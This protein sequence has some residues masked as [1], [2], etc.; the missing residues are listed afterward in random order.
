GRRAVV[1][2]YFVPACYPEYDQALLRG[3]D[4][5]T[6]AGIPIVIGARSFDVNGKPLGC[7]EI[8]AAAH[9]IGALHGAHPESL[10]GEFVVP[11]CIRHGLSPPV[12]SLSIAGFAAARFPDSILDLRPEGQRVIVC[13]RRRHFEPGQREWRTETDAF[14]VAH[15]GRDELSGFLYP[16]AEIFYARVNQTA[17]AEQDGQVVGL[18]DVLTASPE[19]L[20]SRFGGRVVLVGPALP[21]TDE[22]ATTD[23]K[24]IFGHQVQARALDSFLGQARPVPIPF[25][26][27]LLRTLSWS[28][29]AA[30]AI[31]IIPTGN[32]VSIR[33]S[34]PL[35]LA[36]CG[37][38][39]AVGVL[40]AAYLSA[41]WM[42]EAA[43]GTCTVLVAG[44]LTYLVRAGR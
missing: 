32:G 42:V 9:S 21:G 22:Y 13:Y 28:L 39:L 5:L 34:A 33:R 40:C 11:I 27:L 16:G 36:S 35:C 3:F 6:A 26:W 19:Q 31:R 24:T 14:D 2:D 29:M 23:G 18:E 38:G 17:P 4:A 30:L 15:A 1:W 8:L 20:R 12:P 44:S 25:L 10:A 43:I 37:V 7:P 41:P